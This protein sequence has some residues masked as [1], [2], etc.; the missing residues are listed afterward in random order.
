MP[1]H[2]STLQLIGAVVLTV[3]G[4]AWAVVV[5]RLLRR[6]RADAVERL[7]AASLPALPFQP[8][9][10]PPQEVVELTPAEQDAFAGLVRQLGDR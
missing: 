3:T 8:Q 6:A 2:V 9:A 1:E 7:T 5:T 4:V 10:G